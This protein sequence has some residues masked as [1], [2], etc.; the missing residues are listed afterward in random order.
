ME[1]VQHEIILDADSQASA[2]KAKLA[3]TLHVEI[4]ELSFCFFVEITVES[5]AVSLKTSLPFT[6]AEKLIFGSFHP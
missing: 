4:S 3:N 1:A 5:T 2:Y 6:A